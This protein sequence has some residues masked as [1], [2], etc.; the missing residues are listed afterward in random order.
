MN[1]QPRALTDKPADNRVQL[2]LADINDWPQDELNTRCAHWLSKPE[3]TRLQHFRQPQAA[4]RFL[5]GRALLRNVLSQYL[6]GP[7][8]EELQFITGAQGKPE[9]HP[10]HG[11][12][13][14]FNLSHSHNM[15]VLAVAEAVAETKAAETTETGI[16]SIEEEGGEGGVEMVGVEGMEVEGA[17]MRGVSGMT[18]EAQPLL[19][20]DIEWTGKARRI[21][22]IARRYFTKHEHT[23]L[24]VLPEAEQLGHFYTLWTLKEAYI[25]ARGLGL[26]AT[27][28]QF[29][30]TFNNETNVATPNNLTPPNNPTLQPTP[31]TRLIPTALFSPTLPGHSG[32]WQFWSL[33]PAADY[34][35]GVSIGLNTPDPITLAAPQ[36][37]TYSK[38]NFD[39]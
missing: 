32:H 34:R 37:N 6:N 25:K 20:V 8:P 21:D 35:I 30:I 33:Q 1:Q 23:E 18:K 14:S 31:T 3:Q 22:N 7:G 4:Q 38:A 5:L 26:G 24:F 10:A 36:E 39:P 13:L 15:V 27:L 28:C 29:T 19:G 9:L 12:K 2:W 17:G 16:E 11:S